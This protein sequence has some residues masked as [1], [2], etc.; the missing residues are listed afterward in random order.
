MRSLYK[1]YLALAI[2]AP[3]LFLVYLAF[4]LVCLPR[5]AVFEL[6]T[7]AVSVVLLT[8]AYRTHRTVLYA[9]SGLVPVVT[10]VISPIVMVTRLGAEK[11]LHDR[12]LAFVTFEIIAMTQIVIIT[13]MASMDRAA[14]ASAER[15]TAAHA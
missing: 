8:L 9:L 7:G 14:R 11:F 6:V 4:D 1:A 2:A 3:P 12:L 15:P 10:V 5:A 13:L